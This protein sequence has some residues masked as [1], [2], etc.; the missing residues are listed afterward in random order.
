MT[1]SATLL[2]P[3]QVERVHE[4]SLEILEDVG[5]L[6]HNQEARARFA[7]HGCRVDAETQ[8][9]TFPRAVVEEFRAAIPPTFTF[10]GRDPRYDRT[11]PDDGP[12][13][14]T[15]SSAPNVI[16]I[17]TRD[18]PAVFAP[19]VDARIRAEFKDLVAG[20]ATPR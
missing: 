5:V 15:G 20:D 18:N 4:A 7:K 11:I 16:D 8:V 13:F 1:A 9:V 19:D 2:N 3:G 10:H 12:L 6:V 17:L 14:V